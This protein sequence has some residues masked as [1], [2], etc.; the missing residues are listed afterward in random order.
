MFVKNHFLK[1]LQALARKNV[2][3]WSLK[4]TH[5]FKAK[6]KSQNWLLQDFVVLFNSMDAGNHDQGHYQKGINQWLPAS[7]NGETVP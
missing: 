7:K 4:K 6:E 2:V 3:L 1:I 5:V